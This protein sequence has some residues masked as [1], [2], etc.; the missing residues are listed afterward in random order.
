MSL[1]DSYLQQLHTLHAGVSE[2]YNRL[3]RMQSEMDRQISGVYH[4]I[5]KM[6]IDE[7]TGP[8]AVKLLQDVLR[9]RRVVKDEL[10]RL[11]PIYCMLADHVDE[12]EK[13][14]RKRVAKSD[15]IRRSL[16]VTLNFNDIGG[17]DY[18]NAIR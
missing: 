12:T 18:E 13:Q 4:E 3:N 11:Q 8:A 10:I 9:K 14:Y 6:E 15:E 7:V 5:E 1:S 2:T 17:F 16:N